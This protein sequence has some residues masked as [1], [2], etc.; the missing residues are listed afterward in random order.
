LAFDKSIFERLHSQGKT[1]SPEEIVDQSVDRSTSDAE[2]VVDH[3]QGR[4][5]F[6]ATGRSGPPAAGRTSEEILNE[7]VNFGLDQVPIKSN[8]F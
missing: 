8:D 1:K 7:I 6:K 2:N 4:A 3:R 5:Q